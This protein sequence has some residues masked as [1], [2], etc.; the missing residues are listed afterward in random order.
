LFEIGD[1]RATDF[2][3]R[4][5][6]PILAAVQVMMEKGEGVDVITVCDTLERVHALERVGGL[7]YLGELVNSVPSAVNAAEYARIVVDAARRRALITAGTEIVK[8]AWDQT[9]DADAAEERAEQAV[10]DAV[11]SQSSGYRPV[12]EVVQAVSVRAER[13]YREPVAAG[14]VRHLDTGWLDLNRVLGGWRPAGLVIVLGAPH[15]G[16]SWFALQAMANVCDAGGRGMFFP[17]EMTAEK[18]V[19][20]L[21]LSASKLSQYRFDL[22]QIEAPEWEKIVKRE[23]EMFDW[24]L[25]IDERSQSIGQITGAIRREQLRKPLDLVVVDYLGLVTGGDAQNRNLQMGQYTRRLKLLARDI[26]VPF[27]VPCQVGGKTLAARNDKRPTLA[28]AY[29]SGHVEQDADVVL[30]LY[31]DEGQQNIMDV[32]VL[33]DRLAGNAGSKCS[34]LFSQFG[35]IKSLATGAL[36]MGLPRDWVED[37]YE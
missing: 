35:E 7:A 6:R 13:N 17:L 24:D 25:V 36:D 34:L 21:C 2:Y 31:R 22:G 12:T 9:Q 30:G 16:K 18:L 33:K 14:Q 32:L 10:L 29:E 3:N 28:D 27:L 1:I 11:R 19:E 20:R 26:G 4:E 8:A 37:S 23:A 15:I 5:H